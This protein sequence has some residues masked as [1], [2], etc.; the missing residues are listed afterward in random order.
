MKTEDN[1]ETTSV[2]ETRDNVE[3]LLVYIDAVGDGT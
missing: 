3:K 2:P 1:V